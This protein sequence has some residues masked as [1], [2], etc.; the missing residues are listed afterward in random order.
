MKNAYTILGIGQNATKSDIINGQKRAMQDKKYSSRE[1][2]IAQKQLTSPTQR[3]G[4]D[5]I[6]PYIKETSAQ[7]LE[8]KIKCVSIDSSDLDPNFF[9]SLT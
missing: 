2:A 7:P 6:Y 5:F 1:I 3:L 9:N 8:S 4:V